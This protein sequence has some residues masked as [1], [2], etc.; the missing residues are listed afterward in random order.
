[1]RGYK[2]VWRDRLVASMCNWLLKHVA[3]DRYEKLIGGSIQL[4]VVAAGWPLLRDDFTDG[5]SWTI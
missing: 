4:G 1:M 3:T 5:E 2:G